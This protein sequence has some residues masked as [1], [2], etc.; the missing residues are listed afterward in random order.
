MG[1]GRYFCNLATVYLYGVGPVGDLGVHG[2]VQRDKLL[3]VESIHDNN[4]KAVI[5][6]R[7][8][9]NL[10]GNKMTKQ[11]S[12]IHLHDSD[13]IVFVSNY[14]ERKHDQS[15]FQEMLQLVANLSNLLTLLA[16]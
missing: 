13:K 5:D 12:D 8:G 1:V 14:E 9:P 10:N 15:A 4:D 3:R 2:P 6:Q 7:S 16:I 11:H